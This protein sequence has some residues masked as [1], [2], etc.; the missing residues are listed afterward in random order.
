MNNNNYPLKNFDVAVEFVTPQKTKTQQ[1]VRKLG[2]FKE[3]RDEKYSPTKR[4]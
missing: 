1:I 4:G 3:Y 2:T